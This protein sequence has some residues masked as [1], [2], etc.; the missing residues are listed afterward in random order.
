[1]GGALLSNLRSA[2]HWYQNKAV[3]DSVGVWRSVYSCRNEE[4]VEEERNG[5]NQNVWKV[6]MEEGT[7]WSWKLL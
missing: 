1:M 3:E 2:W 5:E 6:E 7:K 4:K